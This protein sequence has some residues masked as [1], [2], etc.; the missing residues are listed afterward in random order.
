MSDLAYRISDPTKIQRRNIDTILK[1]HEGCKFVMMIDG[2]YVFYNPSPNLELGHK[3]YFK[4]FVG[5]DGKTYIGDASNLGGRPIEEIEWAAALLPDGKILA[6]LYNHDYR[7]HSYI[8]STGVS[9][10]FMIDGDSS[11]TYYR[12]GGDSTE[13]VFGKIV[14]KNGD[15]EFL[16]D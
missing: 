15:V 4:V 6:S 10:T 9:R 16:I 12:R 13:H 8:D 7:E 11:Q 2:A 5:L 14:I 3:H 1:H